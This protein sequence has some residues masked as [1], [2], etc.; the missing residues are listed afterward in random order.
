MDGDNTNTKSPEQPWLDLHQQKIWRTFW[1]GA[2][3]LADRLNEDLK[4]DFGI[5]MAEYDI[6]VRL[7]EQADRTLRMAQL[8]DA[9]C[10]SRS[11]MTH[12]VQRMENLGLVTRAIAPDDRRGILC[13]LTDAGYSMLVKSAPTH[14][15]GVRDNLVDLAEPADF[16]AMG[17]IMDA[18][19][20]KLVAEHPA[21][22][23]RNMGPLGEN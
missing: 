18:L 3:L 19:S 11:R 10:H 21:I 1:M 8:A 14:V 2:T 13:T 23:L 9:L 17:R 22:E 12:T 6:M 5:S 7:S 4:H 20:N 15:R 16:E